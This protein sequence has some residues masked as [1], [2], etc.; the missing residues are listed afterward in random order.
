MPRECNLWGD[1]FADAALVAGGVDRK[2]VRATY[3][4]YAPA[5]ETSSL[6]CADRFWADPAHG[7][8]RQ[9]RSQSGEE[10]LHQ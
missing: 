10:E 8:A 3:H 9:V 2:N 6:A 1:A 4:F 7:H 5:Y